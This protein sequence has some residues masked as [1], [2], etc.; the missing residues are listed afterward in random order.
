VHCGSSASTEELD[1]YEAQHV[2]FWDAMATLAEHELAGGA[3]AG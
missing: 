1:R 3:A 2:E